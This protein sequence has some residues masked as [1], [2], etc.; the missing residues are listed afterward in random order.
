MAIA[1][2]G[3]KSKKSQKAKKAVKTKRPITRKNFSPKKFKNPAVKNKKTK[4]KPLATK[5]KSRKSAKTAKQAKPIGKV[6][7]FY[8]HIGVAIVK[9]NQ[10]IAIGTKLQFKGATTDFKETAKSMQYNHVLIAVAPKGK[11]IGIK[12]AK[13][14][15]EG[16]LV[17]KAE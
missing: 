8:G 9:F 17:Y 16:D 7:H 2:K 13:K 6:T 1:K 14:T 11:Q 4:T 12:V 15:H 10:K 3:K 5:S